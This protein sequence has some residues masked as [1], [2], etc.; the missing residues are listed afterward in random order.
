[1][2]GQEAQSSVNLILFRPR[3]KR[4]LDVRPRTWAHNTRISPVAGAMRCRHNPRNMSKN[5]NQLATAYTV[6]DNLMPIAWSPRNLLL[7]CLDVSFTCS[8]TTASFRSKHEGI[9]SLQAQHTE[10]CRGDE[11]H[12]A[13]DACS[14]DPWCSTPHGYTARTIRVALGTQMYLRTCE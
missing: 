4:G 6:A 5:I 13:C 12:E 9:P 14:N 1:M 3:S 11:R 10:D 8:R 2:L 7:T